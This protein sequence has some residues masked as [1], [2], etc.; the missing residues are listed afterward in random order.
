MTLDAAATR[1]SALVASYLGPDHAEADRRDALALPHWAALAAGGVAYVNPPYL[2]VP[3]LSRFLE[4]AAATAAAGVTTVA[5]V[6][7]STG[8]AWWW[9][10]VV[11]TGASVEFLRGR[12]AFT[13]PHAKPGA[14]APWPSALVFWQAAA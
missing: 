5:L 10:H 9:R 3:V 1:D 11:D 4:R 14:T 6:P 7:A 12:L 2:P 13:G 8:A